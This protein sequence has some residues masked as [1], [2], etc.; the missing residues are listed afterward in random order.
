MSVSVSGLGGLEV[1]WCYCCKYL[2]LLYPLYMCSSFFSFDFHSLILTL[3]E[4]R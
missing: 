2:Y 4:K 3:R 1:C